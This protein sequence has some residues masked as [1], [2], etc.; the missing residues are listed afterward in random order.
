MA[1]VAAKSL[2]EF[3]VKFLQENQDKDPT[4]IPPYMIEQFRKLLDFMNSKWVEETASRAKARSV[5]EAMEQ[6]VKL[7][8]SRAIYE[9]VNRDLARLNVTSDPFFLREQLLLFQWRVAFFSKFFP[10]EAAVVQY[11]GMFSINCL[12]GPP[13]PSAGWWRCFGAGGFP[14]GSAAGDQYPEFAVVGMVFDY[15]VQKAFHKDMR[16]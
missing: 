12:L 8:G 15:V 9:R 3:V 16:W 1:E 2:K 10:I 6:Q 11:T 5:E 7:V 4:E 14:G 13:K